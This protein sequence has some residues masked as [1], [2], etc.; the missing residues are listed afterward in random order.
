MSVSQQFA[1]A[2]PGIRLTSR[3]QE[4]PL[5]HAQT[6]SAPIADGPSNSQV[7]MDA[8]KTGS[9]IQSVPQQAGFEERIFNALVALKVATAQYAMHLPPLE[10][11]R[12]FS[13]L[14][15]VI[16]AD[17]WH[18]EDA[19][20]LLSSFVNFLKWII[21][22][23][24]F[25]WSSIGVSDEGHVLVAWVIPG[26]SLTANFFPKNKVN[27]TASVDSEIGAAHTAGTGTLQH[28]TKQALFYL[29]GGAAA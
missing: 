7:L 20:P 14:D 29:S 25:A 28:F 27:W 19:L 17:D 23:K 16:N 6:S 13:R 21:F 11:A 12:L 8:Q 15:E 9:L 22:S 10:R 2:S 26:L 5:P 4:L 18:E 1:V 24:N 3:W